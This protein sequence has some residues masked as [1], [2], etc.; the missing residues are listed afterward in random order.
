MFM[1]MTCRLI[2]LVMAAGLLL[3]RGAE[4]AGKNG[5]QTALT[6]LLREATLTILQEG[7]TRYAAGR[8]LHPNQD[9]ARRLSTAAE[10]QQPLATVLACS[11]SR[12]PVELIFDRGLGELFV[13]RV[14]GNVADTD[15]LATIEYGVDHLETPLLLVVGHSRCGAV[16]AAVTGAELHGHLPQLVAKIKPAVEKAKAGGADGLT[17]IDESIRANVWQSVGDILR[18]S[19]IVRKRV[20]AGNLHVVGAVYDLDSGM[21]RWLGV[22]PEQ[23]A[24]LAQTAV[25]PI[26]EPAP[27]STGP[28][29]QRPKLVEKP[30][31]LAHP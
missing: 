25:D 1:K 24:L 12:E 16:T 3:A 15:Q 9:V 27:P 19:E 10:G 22:H 23:E 30:R 8:P 4:N 26:T 28:L 21:V 13:V 5:A 7:N 18:R 11:D 20:Q 14:A 17:I 31:E 2:G 29:V 6:K